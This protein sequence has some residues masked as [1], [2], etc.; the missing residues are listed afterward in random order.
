MADSL[1]EYF[2]QA[3]ES[4][5]LTLE[6]AALRT[7][8]LPEYLKAVEENNYARLPEEVFAKGFVR[9]YARVL[10][11]DE[12]EVFQKFNE[13]GGQFYAKRA[14]REEIKQRLQEE[15]RRK[16]INQ[17]MVV[18]MVAAALVVLFMLTGPDRAK[19]SS[20]P[21]ATAPA[22][23]PATTKP[24]DSAPRVSPKPAPVPLPQASANPAEVEQNF[25]TVL[26]LEGIV[27]DAKKLV[28][29]IEAT[30]RCWVLVRADRG[31]EQDV[32][33]NPGERVRW[34]A[35]ERFTLTL[36]NAGGVRISFNGKPQGPYGDSGK[37]VKDIVLSQ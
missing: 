16:K 18:G 12:Y 1:G 15:E 11:L 24:A 19:R 20:R 27:P 17:M 29:D 14:E 36:G 10:G 6:D 35:Q 4:K 8:I 32:M 23:A 26:P 30:E 33:L 28:L 25:S 2:Q 22:P 9:S 34:N 21:Q 5:G 31:P 13:S 3:R 37:V 7:R